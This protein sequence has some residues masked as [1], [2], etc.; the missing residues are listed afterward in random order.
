[1]SWSESVHPEQL[2]E[3]LYSD[4]ASPAN[5]KQPQPPEFSEFPPLDLSELARQRRV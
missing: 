1:V 4:M 3:K 2:A 5:R